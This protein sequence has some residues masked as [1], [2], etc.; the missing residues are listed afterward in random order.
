MKAGRPITMGDIRALGHNAE[1]W[2]GGTAGVA[3]FGARRQR[4]AAVSY[5]LMYRTADGR[6]RRVT[7]GR[8]GAPWTP[9]TARREARRL[10][11]EVAAGRD[12][13]LLRQRAR[14]AGTV[15]ALCDAYL[16]AAEAGRLLKRDGTRK[17]QSTLATDRSR[18][19]AHIKPLLGHMRPQAVTRQHVERFMQQVIEGHTARRQKLARPHALSAVKGGRG[20]A[21]RTMGLLGA[22]F[23]WAQRQ[24]LI[25]AN[26][27]R[28]ITR[29]AD[30][31]RERRLSEAEHAALGRA[32]AA[33][34][35]HMWPPALAAARFMLLTGWRRG[36]VLG[37]R[38]GNIDLARQSAR[39]P[40]T[41]TGA[42][43]RPLAALACDILRQAG[44][45]EDAALVF[46]PARGDT[47]MTGFRSHWRR[48]REAAGLSADVTPHVL[49]HSFASVAADLGLSELTIAALIGHRRGSMTAR[50]SHLADRALIEAADRV[51]AAIARK[52]GAAGGQ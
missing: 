7:I 12:P 51:A 52:L 2:D 17:R 3:G 22:I 36:E 35:G 38:W 16:E 10:L 37:L 40:D 26:P 48:I 8:H 19:E 34:E 30:G 49:R 15:A 21:A 42:S 4:S 20:A 5:V 39:L 41:K 27:V 32:L 46:P 14:G 50:Y 23:A 6:Q 44:R 25:E 33:L 28:G 11:G 18:I 9:E 43:I 24:A 1:I 31:T 13:A 47:A 45:R 29:P